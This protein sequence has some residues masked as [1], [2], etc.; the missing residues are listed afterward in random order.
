MGVQAAN[1]SFSWPTCGTSFAYAASESLIGT[2]RINYKIPGNRLREGINGTMKIVPKSPA[3]VV[4]ELLLKPIIDVTYSFFDHC[5]QAIKQPLASFDAITS[6]MLSFPPGAAAEPAVFTCRGD[7]C[8]D[9]AALPRE[10]VFT[11]QRGQQEEQVRGRVGN[12]GVRQERQTPGTTFSARG[13]ELPETTVITAPPT[14]QEQQL[15]GKVGSDGERAPRSP[16]TS[17]SQQRGCVGN[18]GMRQD[19]PRRSSGEAEKMPAS[20]NVDAQVRGRVGR[21]QP[22]AE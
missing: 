11:A 10:T 9:D 12:D 13:A 14:L 5:F 1:Q 17:E 7:R 4:G 21:R 16:V 2:C 8:N 19:C 3:Y 22:R 18:D 15:R 6:R 20:S